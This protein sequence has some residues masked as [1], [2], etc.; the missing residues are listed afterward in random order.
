MLDALREAESRRPLDFR[1]SGARLTLGRAGRAV[2]IRL[3]RARLTPGATGKLGATSL[4]GALMAAVVES[5]PT[6]EVPP[7][8]GFLLAEVGSHRVVAPESFTEE[9]RLYYRTAQQFA[10]ERVL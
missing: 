8:G 2:D 9:Q 7:G 4:K 1:L 5:R 3:S 6:S 10:R